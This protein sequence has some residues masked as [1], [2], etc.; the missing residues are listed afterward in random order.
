MLSHSW[1]ALQTAQQAPVG[2]GGGQVTVTRM[3]QPL[4]RVSA[5]SAAV[6][7]C[8]GQGTEHDHE[9]IRIEQHRPVSEDT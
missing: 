3:L 1:P 4:I 5:E 2:V 7:G 9:V 8:V 6:P